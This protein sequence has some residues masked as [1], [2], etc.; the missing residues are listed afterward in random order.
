MNTS[1]KFIGFTLVLSFT[2]LACGNADEQDQ[3][4][5]SE[6]INSLPMQQLSL[7]N[8]EAFRSTGRNWSIA[9]NVQSDYLTEHSMDILEGEGVLVNSSSE[10]ENEHIFTEIEHG[11]IE[12][13]LQFLVPKRSNSGIYFQGRYEAQ[14]L[15]SWKVDEPQFYDVGGIYERWDES[16]PEEERG[17][18]GVAP[19]VNAGLAPGLWQD[20]HILFRA[21]RFDNA[22][23][24]I[25]NARFERVS[26][27]GVLIHENVEVTGPT[28]AAA[29]DDEAETGPLMFQGDHGP[30]AFRNIEYKLYSQTDSLRLGQLE[31]KV[32][33]YD[34]DR[35]PVNFDELELLQ[36]GVT[37]SFNV[38]ALSPKSENFATT[39]TGDL[40]VPI[41][42]DY[43]FETQ[44]NNGGNLYINGNLIIE[45]TGEFD[46][47]R[48][49]T[50]IHL[51]EGTHEL[52]LTH[53]QI[54]WG[55]F[56]ILFYE[57]PGMEHRTLASTAPSGGGSEEEPVTVQV[58]TDRPERVGGFTNYIG[59]KRTHTLSVGHPE[60]I[61]YSYDLNRASFLKFWRDP[62]ADV[63]QMWQGRG[64]EQLLVPMNA[65]VEETAGIP[66]VTMGADDMFEN[67]RM[68][69]DF[70]VSEYHLN[71]KGQPVFT[72]YFDGITIED[73]IGPSE[74]G[75]EFIR[76]LRFTADQ[77]ENELSARIAQGTSVELLPNGLYRIDG[78]YYL[79]ILEDQ[80]QEP[81]ISEGGDT[82][83]LFI[84][85]LRDSEQSE[86]QYQVIW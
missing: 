71:E 64:H 19:N 67:H 5:G 66:V 47:Q 29:F 32:Y 70:E 6:E 46:S 1:I 14:I 27:N 81:E 62:F 42:G 39:F 77:T 82:Q 33:D 61:H 74:N 65:A 48:L 9:G 85:V 72:S 28:R 68:S 31:Y 2:L 58:T 55:T 20:Y 84:P 59:E 13:R 12:L 63:S 52:K 8:L 36:E 30:V 49:G 10:E 56:A 76:T 24:K 21:P 60:G 43:L 45:N 44:M 25:E 7:D 23:N 26:L 73:H 35:T 75:T 83:A 50:I 57:G 69:D 53:F 79:E 86:I 38:A 18:E 78:R 15:D 40:E 34:G 37:D 11:D 41:T 54:M 16:L 22:G 80:G 51:T 4:L 17:Y 3:E